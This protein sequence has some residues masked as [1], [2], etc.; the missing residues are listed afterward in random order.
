[1]SSDRQV[2][3]LLV[4][5]VV[6][7]VLAVCSLAMCCGCAAQSG[8]KLTQAETVQQQQ[9]AAI[10]APVLKASI[11][12]LRA[13]AEVAVEQIKATQ[14]AGR[15]AIQQTSTGTPWYAMIAGLGLLL[16]AQR[17]WGYTPANWARK[18][19]SANRTT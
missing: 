2:D 3:W 7:A 11:D 4:L 15:D 5:V 18:I 10:I 6:A 8:P 12:E 17:K 9:A 1:M 14:T 19:K 13:Q 16:W